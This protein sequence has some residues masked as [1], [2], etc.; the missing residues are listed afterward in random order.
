MNGTFMSLVVVE[1][2]LTGAA[3][4]MFLYRGM[5]DM[6]EEDHLILDSAEAHLSREQASIRHKVDVV[7]KY[8]KVIAVVWGVLLVAIFG[9][10]VGQGLG[11]I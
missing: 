8:L 3:I 9:V 2:V 5:L 1:A 10:W 7:S 4:V 11:F 6:K